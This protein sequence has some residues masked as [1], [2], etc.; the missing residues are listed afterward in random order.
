MPV[1]QRIDAFGFSVTV[2]SDTAIIGAEVK[3]VAQTADGA[4]YSYELTD[5][6][7]DGLS[8]ALEL[9]IC[10]DTSSAGVSRHQ[11]GGYRR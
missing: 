8:D 6:D 7:D 3:D 9:K 11:P 1:T 4:I 5:T 10:A 2:D